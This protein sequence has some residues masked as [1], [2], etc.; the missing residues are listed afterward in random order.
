MRNALKKIQEVNSEYAKLTGRSYGNGLI[1]TYQLDDAEIAIVVVGSS[2]GTLKVIVDQLRE[3][4]VKAGVLRLRT[5]PFPVEACGTALKNVKTIAVMDK[6]M[7]FGGFGGPV[8]MEVRKRC[9]MQ[10]FTQPS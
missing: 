6:S 10:R 7:S 8:F 4:G 9:T 2:A 5:P 3:E 1:D